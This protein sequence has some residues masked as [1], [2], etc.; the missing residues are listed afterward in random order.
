MRVR[1]ESSEYILQVRCFVGIHSISDPVCAK[2]L[3]SQRL[4]NATD[5]ESTV[6]L[7]LSH[8]KLDQQKD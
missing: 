8:T 6:R 2:K 1:G 7:D 3:D 5:G 4:S